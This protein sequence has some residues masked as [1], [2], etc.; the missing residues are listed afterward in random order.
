MDHY[1]ARGT[2]THTYKYIQYVTELRKDRRSLMREQPS[3]SCA[4]DL[5][6]VAVPVVVAAAVAAAVVVSVLLSRDYL[7]GLQF[8]IM[9]RDMDA[10]PN[11]AAAPAA[12][13]RCSCSPLAQMRTT[14]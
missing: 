1:L 4:L 6:R 3:V 11:P 13:A 7:C 5:L 2:H 12:P 8:L 14:R 9:H 10:Q